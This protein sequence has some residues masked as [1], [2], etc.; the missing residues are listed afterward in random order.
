RGDDVAYRARPCHACPGAPACRAARILGGRNE[1]VSQDFLPM[2]QAPALVGRSR[3]SARTRLEE[4]KLRR[5]NG[6]SGVSLADLRLD[7]HGCCVKFDVAHPGFAATNYTL[8][9]CCQP[10]RT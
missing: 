9:G 6:A 1:G 2:G 5:G 4:G 8:T 7:P 3:P 10:A